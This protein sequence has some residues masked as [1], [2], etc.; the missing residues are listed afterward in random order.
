MPEIP[1]SQY[2][3]FETCISQNDISESWIAENPALGQAAIRSTL[4]KTF[5]CQSD[6]SNPQV[7]T[8]LSK[9]IKKGR[10]IIEYPFID[11]DHWKT[12]IP[13][14]FWDGF[15][16]ILRRVCLIMDYLHLMDMAHRDLKFENFMMRSANDKS[17]VIRADLDFPRDFALRADFF[18]TEF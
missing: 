15:A 13:G 16:D 1:Q 5:E 18:H 12:L 14:L 9:R 6:L 3:K 4:T 11:P 7:N 10:L 8:A 2:Y 17:V